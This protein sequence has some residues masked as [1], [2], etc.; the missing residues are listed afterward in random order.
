MHH[1]HEMRGDARATR[2]CASL[3]EGM[4]ART[5]CAASKSTARLYQSKI[6]PASA[7][8]ANAFDPAELQA[9]CAI[10]PQR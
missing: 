6:R 4:A 10:F 3:G 5:S 8:L 1:G 2:D 7:L 9:V